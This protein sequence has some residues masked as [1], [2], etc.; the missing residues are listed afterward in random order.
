LLLSLGQNNRDMVVA[1]DNTG[2]TLQASVLLNSKYVKDR[3]RVQENGRLSQFLNHDP[4]Y[5][6]EQIVEEIFLA[7]LSRNPLPKEKAIA[8]QTLQERH[9]HGLED[10]AWSLINKP[11][12]YLND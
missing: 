3:I 9:G 7:F 2:S 1:K 4:P 8:L 11:E 10:L 6:N 12:F 5:S